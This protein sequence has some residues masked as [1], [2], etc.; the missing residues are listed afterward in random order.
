MKAT[1]KAVAEFQKWLEKNSRAQ[2]VPGAA[3]KLTSEVIDMSIE[4]PEYELRGV[5]TK[6][7][8]PMI[9]RF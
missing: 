5:E 8:N 4:R 6:S 2:V 9:F 1:K 7:G 3:E